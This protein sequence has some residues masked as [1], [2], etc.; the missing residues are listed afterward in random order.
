MDDAA[1]HLAEAREYEKNGALDRALERYRMVASAADPA[2]VSQGL[3]GEASVHRTRC[4]W[5]HAIAAARRA[6]DAARGAGLSSL[7]AEAL[8][9]ESAV[10]QSRGD[11][12]SAV[13]LLERI[14]TVTDDPRLRGI[15]L[16]NLGGIAGQR[17]DLETAER[18]FLESYRCFRAAGY[19]WGEAFA[20]NNYGA[21]ALDR[22]SFELAQPVLE[23]AVEAAK[24]LGD[25]ELLAIALKN[26]AEAL[27]GQG[28]LDAA[29]DRASAA[30]GYFQAT[31]NT[32]RQVECFQLLGDITMRQG[33][34]EAAVG[35]WRHGLRL[36]HAIGANGDAQRLEERIA[37]CEMTREERESGPR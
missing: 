35:C 3:C 31:N 7:E 29:E 32:W 24:E 19:A 14:L 34:C 1:D 37:E 10:H 36:A 6:A 12:A 23:Q 4:E 33:H 13:P 28:R 2:L 15:A 25:L 17:G 8:N 20:M 5:D 27:A 26:L 16:Q 21:V 11:F 18:R 30:L 9:A 22:G